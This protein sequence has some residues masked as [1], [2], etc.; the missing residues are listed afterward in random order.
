MGVEKVRLVAFDVDGVLTDGSILIDG[1]GR[2]STKKFSVKDGLGIALLRRAGLP[3]AFV[4]GRSSVALEAR[5]RELD[6]KFLVQ[7][8]DDKLGALREIAHTAGVREEEIA[9]MGDDL[10]DLP[11]LRRVGY[12]MCPA[13]AAPELREVCQLVTRA[14]GGE[15]CAREAAEKILR[16]QDRWSAILE[17]F[18]A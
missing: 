12:A 1:E 4:S 16:G 2:E 8:S 11:V 13:D 3:V 17:R 15:G 14:K 18:L 7:G 9:Y 5:A 6:V 10:P